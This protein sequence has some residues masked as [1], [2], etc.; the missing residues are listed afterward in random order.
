MRG[1]QG[2][3]QEKGQEGRKPQVAAGQAMTEV[4]P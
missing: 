2:E 3:G 1:E 4:E